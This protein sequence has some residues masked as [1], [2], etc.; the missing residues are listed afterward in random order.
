MGSNPIPSML[1]MGLYILF[2]NRKTGYYLKAMPQSSANIHNHILI[3]LEKQIELLTKGSSSYYNSLFKKLSTENRDNAKI[4]YKFLEAEHNIQNVKN[5]TIVTHIKAICLFNEYLSYKDF[6]KITKEDIIYYLGS[7]R[8]AESNDPTHKWIG[9][10]NTRQMVLNKF[11]R[12]LYNHHQNNESDHE[13]WIPPPYMQGIKQ[14]SRKEKSPYKPS[15]IWTDEDHALF[16]KYCPE[17]RD[18]CYHAMANDTS[19]RPHELLSLKLKD[20]KFKV[21]STGIQYAEVHI[22]ESKT[23][24]TTLPLVFSIPY[25]KDWMIPILLWQIIPIHFYSFH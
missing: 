19:C 22:Q 18:K 16:L 21:S 13:K 1:F 6:E 12:W 5:S 14:L 7:L 10:Y 3:D 9:T 15:D 25:V 2:I 8:K 17:K 24:P 23:K 20:I 11:F 4:H